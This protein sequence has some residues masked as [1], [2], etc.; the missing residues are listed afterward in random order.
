MPVSAVHAQSR[1]DTSFT[2]GRNA[3]LDIT[4]R[5]GYLLVRGS[6]RDDGE[7]RTNSTG[8]DIKSSGSGVVVGVGRDGARTSRGRDSE[9]ARVE[10]SVPRGVRLVISGGR[11]DIE[12]D[13]IDGDVEVRSTSSDI[14]LRRLGGRAIVESLS[15]DIVISEGVGALR[16]TTSSG[17]LRVEGLRGNADVHTTSG[18]VQVSGTGVSRFV[19]ET[20]TGDVTLDG[21]ITNDARVQVSTHTG[22]VLMRLPDRTGGELQFSTFNGEIHTAIPLTTGGTPT[23]QS[24]RERQTGQRYTF[25]GGG[26]AVISVSTFNGDFRFERGSGRL[27]ER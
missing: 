25:G 2:I 26:S 10:I 4:V 20:I 6:N 18:D 11:A 8:I 16:A 14:T 27:I 24:N 12:V 23:G 13:G 21:S 9:S 7:I 19:V 5:D 17:D 3:L 15:G 1:G 22:D